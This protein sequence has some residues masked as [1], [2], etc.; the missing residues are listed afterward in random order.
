MEFHKL[1]VEICAIILQKT[2]TK[3]WSSESICYVNDIPSPKDVLI[4]QGVVTTKYRYD[5]H[6]K[7]V[8]SQRQKREQWVGVLALASASANTYTT[9]VNGLC[10]LMKYQVPY[11]LH[12]NNSNNNNQATTSSSHDSAACLEMK[13]ETYR[14]CCVKNNIQIDLLNCL[15]NPMFFNQLKLI[16]LLT[17]TTRTA[18][19]KRKRD[20]I[21]TSYKK[22]LSSIPMIQILP[23]YIDLDH[24]QYLLLTKKVEAQLTMLNKLRYYLNII[25][26][27]DNLDLRGA[28]KEN[29]ISIL[30]EQECI[31]SNTKNNDIYALTR[32]VHCDS[33]TQGKCM[34]KSEE[35]SNIAVK[36]IVCLET[37]ICNNLLHNFTQSLQSIFSLRLSHSF[38]DIHSCCEQKYNN[39]NEFRIEGL[40]NLR[41]LTLRL[42]EHRNYYYSSSGN[43]IGD[44]NNKSLFPKKIVIRDLPQLKQIDVLLNNSELHIHKLPRLSVATIDVPH[45]C[46]RFMDDLENLTILNLKQ[47]HSSQIWG[48]KHM[49]NLR[50]FHLT[51]NLS[52]P[53][54]TTPISPNYCFGDQIFFMDQEE[55]NNNDYDVT[56]MQIWGC[57]LETL[58]LHGNTHYGF[59]LLAHVLETQCMKLSKLCFDSTC[60]YENL[61]DSLCTK[62]PDLVA[63]RIKHF[64][65]IG[66]NDI[67]CPRMDCFRVL[68][69]YHL[70]CAQRGD[71][72]PLN[73]SFH[74]DAHLDELVLT[75]INTNFVNSDTHIR[76]NHLI[77]CRPMLKDLSFLFT[78]DDTIIKI[79]HLSIEN[80]R[81]FTKIKTKCPWPIQSFSIQDLY[82]GYLG[83]TGFQEAM[84]LKKLNISGRMFTNNKSSYQL[85]CRLFPHLVQ[86]C[87][88]RNVELNYPNE[89]K[90][91]ET[92]VLDKSCLH[93]LVK[94]GPI[95]WGHGNR[96]LLI[97]EPLSAQKDQTTLKWI[98]ETFAYVVFCKIDRFVL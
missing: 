94:R 73:L 62:C 3:T 5:K 95:I 64:I 72:C 86:L 83:F 28:K 66:L 88:T 90:C 78:H 96:V 59:H 98:S 57:N 49:F 85:D 67:Q 1:P 71:T 36:N 27:H 48:L 12:N 33:S 38:D 29:L 47:G 41:K 51:S 56:A 81:D 19:K 26:L 39:F 87:I 80:Q 74:P 46:A 61:F 31:N 35:I 70:D 13:Q 82:N 10:Y 18:K 9:V 40:R 63:N 37:S 54:N 34:F 42:T 75:T 55:N 30:Q 25:F 76:A 15:S 97:T 24:L 52:Y 50:T 79:N 65:V 60:K 7:S 17:T 53:P 21:A 20:D 6:E 32:H 91:L 11:P 92:L 84:N 16:D 2:L 68:K 44:D 43:G 69:S 93:L 22:S 58:Y 45:S 14:I 4:K 77:L 8:L 23:F 89:L